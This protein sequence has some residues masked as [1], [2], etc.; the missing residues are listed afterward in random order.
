LIYSVLAT[1]A[2]LL[3]PEGSPGRVALAAGEAGTFVQT[4]LILASWASAT[5]LFQARLAHASYTAGPR[6]EWPDSPAAEAITNLMP[7]AIP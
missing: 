1:A 4:F 5:T 2:L 6:L 3:A 7:S